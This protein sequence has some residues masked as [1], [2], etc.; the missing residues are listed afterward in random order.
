MTTATKT[1]TKTTTENPTEIRIK[2][3]RKKDTPALRRRFR[4]LFWQ[5]PEATMLR[6]AMINAIVAEECG[7]NCEFKRQDGTCE[8]DAER[9]DGQR[10]CPQEPAS[11]TQTIETSNEPGQGENAPETG[12]E[13]DYAKARDDALIADC[14]AASD[15]SA[16]TL[17]EHETLLRAQAEAMDPLDED[18]EYDAAQ[19]EAE[20]EDAA[21]DAANECTEENPCDDCRAGD[22]TPALDEEEEALA[23]AVR[24][25]EP[26][27]DTDGYPPAAGEAKP[28][29]RMVTIRCTP[30]QA[31]NIA[32]CL[33]N[34]LQTLD[35]DAIIDALE[36]EIARCRAALTPKTPKAP[37]EPRTG[38]PEHALLVQGTLLQ[39]RVRGQTVAEAEVFDGGR[40]YYKSTMYKSISGAASAAATDLGLTTRQNGYVFWGVK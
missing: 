6:E 23:E 34:N 30:L 13:D 37:R 40:V 15:A 17:A 2:A 24:A 27:G 39:R 36:A 3:I 10:E 9:C 7:D 35:A 28:K 11:A 14:D 19:A 31:A 4:E 38:K 18:A 20:A 22:D 16:M 25:M 32:E 8:L 12:S 5:A 29:L 21:E 1:T 33:R 26:E